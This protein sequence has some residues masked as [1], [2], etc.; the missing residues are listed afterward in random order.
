M[1][2]HLL[3]SAFS[4]TI[5]LAHFILC[6]LKTQS[7]ELRNLF[8]TPASP[9]SAIFPLGT[10][11]SLI[12]LLWVCLQSHTN[13]FSTRPATIQK[14][15]SR[16]LSFLGITFAA[17]LVIYLDVFRIWYYAISSAWKFSY[18]PTWNPEINLDIIQHIV[19]YQLALWLSFTAGIIS[20]LPSL[21]MG[22]ILAIGLEAK[23][24]F[25]VWLHQPGKK[26][27]EEKKQE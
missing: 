22:F 15:T 7:A 1:T 18:Q 25:V 17:A 16:Y 20:L 5:T 12:I 13:F 26:P 21:A 27:W 19:F 6:I 9:T 10:Y 24:E 23:I 2:F 14:E 3:L 8:I 4:I 11:Y